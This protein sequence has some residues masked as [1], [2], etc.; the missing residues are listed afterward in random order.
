[1]FLLVLLAGCA[2]TPTDRVPPPTL[3]VNNTG[4]NWINIYREDSRI[5]NAP[6][7]RVSC[8]IL[9]GLPETAVALSFRALSEH[10]VEFAPSQR[11][12]NQSG[13]SI[14]LMNVRHY[15]ML[16]LQPAARCK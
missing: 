3:R 4:I 7:G 1:M 11:F 15:E 5:G 9:H 10:E 13:W 16:S 6:P 2:T 8:I 12:Q 14:D